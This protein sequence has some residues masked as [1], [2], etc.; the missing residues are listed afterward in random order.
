MFGAVADFVLV[1]R[2][3]SQKPGDEL[4]ENFRQ[5]FPAIAGTGIASTSASSGDPNPAVPTLGDHDVDVASHERL[6][7][8]D[9]TMSDSV[10][11]L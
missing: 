9:S 2:T 6:V 5:H 1:Y 7:A 8:R 10:S 3:S 4:Y 11:A